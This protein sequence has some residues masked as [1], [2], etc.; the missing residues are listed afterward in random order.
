MT[1]YHTQITPAVKQKLE[2]TPHILT[3]SWGAALGALGILG[4]G[5]LREPCETSL[6]DVPILCFILSRQRM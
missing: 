2:E 3:E 6:D 4:F 5:H 1:C